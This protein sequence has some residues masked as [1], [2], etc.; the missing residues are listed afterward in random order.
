MNTIAHE[1]IASDVTTQLL[2]PREEM[3]NHRAPQSGYVHDL[4]RKI[5]AAVTKPI[6]MLLAVS[7]ADVDDGIPVEIAVQPY[8]SIISVL[9]AHAA[10]RARRSGVPW[11]VRV[12][13]V[14]ERETI[15]EGKLNIAQQRANVDPSN[16]AL[17]LDVRQCSREYAAIQAELDA[18]I[19]ERWAQSAIAAAGVA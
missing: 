14:L 6:A 12:R 18:L 1:I 8:E 3:L 9:R 10:R 4:R 5:K 13:R 19:D 17:L 2:Q 16:L 15:A 7:I 11:E